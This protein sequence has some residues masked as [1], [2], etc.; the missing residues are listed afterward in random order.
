[1]PAMR[2]GKPS[3]ESAFRKL[4]EA[5]VSQIVIFPLYPQYSLSAT[6]SSVV[7][8]RQVYE[9]VF[10]ER[11]TEGEVRAEGAGRPALSWVPPFYD[12]PGFIEA[13]A[14]V[15]EAQAQPDH[16]DHWLFSFHGLPERHV[17]RLA[18]QHC[19]K[20][21]SCCEVV[22][23]ANR[24]CYRAQCY[25]TA[26]LL[27]K[28]LGIAQEQYTVCFQ[29]RLGRTPWIQPYSDTLYE[30]LPQQGIR[31]VAV[32]C[33]A[34]VADCLETLEEVQMRGQEQFQEAGGQTLQLMHSLN[35]T[36]VW[37][38]QVVRLAREFATEFPKEA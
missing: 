7:Q 21:S 13:F 19:L 11:V 32:A 5:Q 17:T 15:I 9:Q 24:S 35:A 4:A 12:H 30:T 29:S 23:D 25:A 20:A 28:R 36:P 18:P 34:F 22:T 1:V 37:A 26:R 8:C 27:A 16:F 3:V 6:E 38:D 33:P 31:K 10:G 14:Q 2:Y